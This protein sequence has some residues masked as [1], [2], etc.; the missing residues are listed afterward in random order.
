MKKSTIEKI[1]KE[2]DEKTKLP[3]EIKEKIRKK[4]F[5]NFVIASIIVLYFIFIVSGSSGAI[6][7]VRIID[8]NIFSMIFLGTAI[9][10]FEI[11]YRK[12]DDGLAVHGMESLAVAIFTLFLPYIIFELDELHK[13]YYLIASIYITIYYIIKTIYV[14]LRVKQQYMNSVS[15]IKDIIKKEKKNKKIELDEIE[16]IDI[17]K[18][19]VKNID[20]NNI[21]QETRKKRG[22]PKKD[23]TLKSK[24]KEK[25]EVNTPKKRG[26]PKKTETKNKS[27]K[28]KEVDAP[29]KRGRPRKENKEI[30][31]KN[32]SQP[33]KRGRPRKV[34]AKK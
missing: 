6:K 32:E 18:E 31:G 2:I 21:K 17:N 30:T 13:K 4:I 16:E 5:T 10:L 3:N 22:R 7:N 29:K 15:D 25:K 34:D 1:E 23:T 24:N 12:D 28:P 20:K 33:K 9:G 11:A 27:N 26:R 14:S 8:L 19:T